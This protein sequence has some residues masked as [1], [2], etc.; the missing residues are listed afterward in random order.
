MVHTG[1]ASCRKEADFLKRLLST[2]DSVDSYVAAARAAAKLAVRATKDL[3]AAEAA[4]E[5]CNHKA[6]WPWARF[7]PSSRPASHLAQQSP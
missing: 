2:A 7:N 3:Q 6:H 5:V 4:N 1:I